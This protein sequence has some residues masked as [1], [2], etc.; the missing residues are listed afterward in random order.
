[1]ATKYC[2]LKLTEKFQL[3]TVVLTG[4]RVNWNHFGVGWYAGPGS[5][6][7]G[8]DHTAPA[9]AHGR[10]QARSGWG[11]GGAGGEPRFLC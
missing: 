11:G 1:M 8:Q 9:T 6:L 5:W 3:P 2:A 4:V 10:G 7:S